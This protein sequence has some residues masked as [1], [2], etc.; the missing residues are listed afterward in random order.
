[1]AATWPLRGGID[2]PTHKVDSLG[3]PITPLALPDRLLLPLQAHAGAPARAIVTV[4][5]P[6]LRGE[7]IAEA[8]G[9]VSAALHAP[10]SGTIA[11]LRDVP[12]THPSGL[13]GPGIVIEPDGA[14]RWRAREPMAITAFDPD[15]ARARIESAGLA[16]LGG[17]GF[18]T[19]S[20]LRGIAARTRVVILNGAE[21]EPYIT[22]DQ[23]LMAQRPQAI[24]RGLDVVLR[25]LEP[26]HCL[27]G[28][29]DNK[30]ESIEALRAALEATDLPLR[31]QLRVIPTRYPSGGEKQLISILTGQQ[32]PR[33]GLP[34]DLGMVCLNVGTCAA[35]GAAV[36]DDVP[37]I[38]RVTTVTGAAI[39]RRANHD[40]RIGTPVS[41][42]LGQCGF[43]PQAAD[44]V[45]VGG[46]MMGF[47]LTDLDAPVM[48]TTNCLLAPSRAEWPAPAP[49]QPCIRCGHCVQACPVDLLPQ[50][51]FWHARADEFEAA[52]R[53]NLMDCIECGACAWVCPS[54]IP[55]VGWYRYAKSS[56]RA[57][58]AQKA[59]ADRARERFDAHKARLEREAGE[60]AARKRARMAE[61]TRSRPAPSA[62]D[63]VTAAPSPADETGPP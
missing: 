50:Q 47:A 16:G 21:C 32:V 27:I 6:V 24:L 35:I 39:R 25:L 31:P 10:T 59:A 44:R 26:E 46:P 51:L 29:E 40:V 4:G 12:L 28:I 23:A 54:H 53:H 45:V 43:D 61:R 58:T 38:E 57:A 52:E 63:D 3:A 34:I 14:D 9:P 13:P 36:L 20:K 1:M 49:E 19:A 55:L 2:P 15:R 22:A 42:L 48:K 60:K 56:I 8:V 33:G 11:A 17:A 5:Q 41:F 37:C 7:V 30:P 62:T 18:P